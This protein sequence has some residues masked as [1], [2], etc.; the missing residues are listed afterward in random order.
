M[1]GIVKCKECKNVIR[2]CRC[3]EGHNNVTYETC[4]K[5]QKI[6]DIGGEEVKAE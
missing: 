6:L 4:P 5:C 1:H 2:Q 3:I